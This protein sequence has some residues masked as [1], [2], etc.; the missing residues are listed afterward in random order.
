MS[1]KKDAILTLRIN[2]KV[3][4]DAMKTAR[5]LGLSL[6]IIVNTYLQD[7]QKTKTFSTTIDDTSMDFY[8]WD[9]Y[10]T[11]DEGV[12]AEEVLA[13]LQK[14]IHGKKMD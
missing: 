1:Y 3:K 7:F 4:K 11:F 12:P 2:T 14:Q 8:K 9:E 5:K 10:V 13:Y 6:S